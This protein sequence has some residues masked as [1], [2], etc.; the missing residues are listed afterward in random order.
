[1][2]RYYL[3]PAKW[4]QIMYMK[5]T[6]EKVEPRGHT[7]WK[8]H[9]VKCSDIHTRILWQESNKRDVQWGEKPQSKYQQH[10]TIFIAN[11]YIREVTLQL[12]LYRETHM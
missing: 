8:I 2:I 12:N 7:E 9:W 6:Q 11:R 1:M 5:W 3:I 10:C 4:S